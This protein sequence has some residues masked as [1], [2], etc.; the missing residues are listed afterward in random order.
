[1]KLNIDEV[2]NEFVNDV[3]MVMLVLLFD[4]LLM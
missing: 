3:D 2:D 4:V 1:M